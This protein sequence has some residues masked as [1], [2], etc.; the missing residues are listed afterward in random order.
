MASDKKR[1]FVLHSYE[2]DH[3]CGQPQ[4]DGI[5]ASLKAVGF[6]TGENLLV[7][8][9]YMDTKRK[10]NT[11]EL[12]AKQA[13]IALA[14]ITE[15]SPDVLVTIDDNAYRTVAMKMV[16]RP[17]SIVFSGMNAQPEDYNVI[18]RSVE[19]WNQPG[20]NVTG[21][22]EKLY[23]VEALRVHA[24]LFPDLER[25]VVLVD[26]SPTGRAI[27]KQIELEI[28]MEQLPCR[29]DIKVVSKFEE[30]KKE[31][32]QA[33][34]DP[35]VGAIYPAALLL[36]DEQGNSYT[37]PDIFAWTIKHSNHPEIALNY[38][39]TRMGLFGGA[40]VD[41]YAMGEQAGE[42]V[43]EILT[44][45][46]AGTMPI[47]EAGRYALAFNLDRADSLNIQL[48]PDILLAADELVQAK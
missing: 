34:S 3:V 23:F 12:I 40:A 27:K 43:A 30:Y 19:S 44:G 33:S 10:N 16:D 5:L 7:D 22:Y 28:A 31:I 24:K 13:E 39:F 37:A 45:K 46:K 29:L 20:H 6:E 47:R 1:L 48:P 25:V 17:V 9:Y 35:K 26:T 38:S 2:R 14:K 36:K 18:A 21:V 41:F 42:M 15:F 4:H 8:S 11:G 32:L